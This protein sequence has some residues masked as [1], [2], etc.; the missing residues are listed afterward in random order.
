MNESVRTILCPNC[1]DERQFLRETRREEYNV[2]GEAME[3]EVPVLV[4][5]TCGETVV[6]RQI[7]EDPIELVF[8]QYRERKGLLT[9]GQIKDIRARYSLSQKAFAGL[10]GMSEAT[11]NRYEQGGL[12]DEAHDNMLRACENPAFVRDLLDRR[13]HLLGDRQRRGVELAMAGEDEVGG[14]VWAMLSRV[15]WTAIGRSGR[16]DQFSGFRPFS[17]ERYAAVF[18]W[19]CRRL[20]RV[21]STEINKLLFYAD[22]LAYKTHGRSLTG[23]AYAKLPYGPVPDGF[24]GLEERLERDELFVAREVEFPTGKLGIEYRRGRNA[25]TQS[26]VLNAED[27]QVLEFVCKEMGG[28]GS[29]RISE[30]SHQERAWQET[31][32]CQKIS[33]HLASDLSLTMPPDEAD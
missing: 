27:E 2:R 9:P 8:V 3:I 21:F 30:R 31:E 33:Y 5:R 20:G 12:Q 14:E 32:D 1:E 29:L 4:C 25:D 7:L 26:F 16:V 10:L 19:F 18:T 17:Y 24:R 28:R 23:S 22:F 15:D 6:D 11:I 13:G